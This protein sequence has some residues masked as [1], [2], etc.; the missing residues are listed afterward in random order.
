MY[1]ILKSKYIINETLN[2]ILIIY[3]YFQ[4]TLITIDCYI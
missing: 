3:K 1:I 4:L 2:N